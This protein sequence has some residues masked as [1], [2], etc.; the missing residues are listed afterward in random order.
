MYAI[1]ILLRQPVRSVLTVG[2]IALCI[3]LM[4][5][6]LGVYR[7]IRRSDPPPVRWEGDK[8]G[9]I[10]FSSLGMM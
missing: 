9:L 3:V 10:P 1:R 7:G 4:L 5:F 6:L 8:K 2:G